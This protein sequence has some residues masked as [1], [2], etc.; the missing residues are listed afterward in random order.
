L[1]S[2]AHHD[3]FLSYA[4]DDDDERVRAIELALQRAGFSLWRDTAAISSRGL[5]FLEEIRRAI[6]TAGRVVVAIGPAAV[7]SEYVRME[8]QYALS[9]DRIVVPA[10]LVDD[11]DLVPPELKNLHTP[12]VEDTA[13]LAELIRVLGEEAPPLGTL[14][15]VP[16]PPPHYRPRSNALSELAACV[17]ADH[18]APVVLDDAGRRV[19]VHGMGGAGKT[20]LAG[21][22][23]RGAS[24]RRAFV[25]GVFWFNQRTGRPGQ[26]VADA[27]QTQF[28]DGT[29]AAKAC[30]IVLDNVDTVRFVEPLAAVL[31][32][33]SRIVVTTRD[34]RI[35][36]MLGA[37]RIDVDDLTTDEALEHLAD[38]TG[39]PLPELPDAA[40][41]L[42]RATGGNVL[43]LTLAGAFL[44]ASGGSYDDLL[45]ALASAD[46]ELLDRE[47]IG[48]EFDG[49]MRSIDASVTRL[50]ESG[51]ELLQDL[52]V[53]PAG[54]TLPISILKRMAVARGMAEHRVAAALDELGGL[55]LVRPEADGVSLH[56]LQRL[57]LAAT[58]PETALVHSRLLDAYGPP[59]TWNPLS[60]EPY[61]YE[62]LSHH[63]VHAGRRAVLVDL[64]TTS[65]A[66]MRTSIARLHDIEPV[67]AD[68]RRA[69]DGDRTLVEAVRLQTAYRAAGA[70]ARRYSPD[71]LRC[72]FR[73]GDVALATSCA[74]LGTIDH[75]LAVIAEGDGR[76]AEL[77]SETVELVQRVGNATA[78]AQ[79]QAALL[80]ISDAAAD[81]LLPEFLFSVEAMAE[82][83]WRPD[84]LAR[85]AISLLE[86]GR[87]SDARNLYNRIEDEDDD[88][89]AE[90]VA[91]EAVHLAR[92]E[93]LD[94][95]R[96]LLRKLP[97]PASPAVLLAILEAERR[98]GAPKAPE[99]L[100]RLL[101]LARKR[102]APPSTS[103]FA[104]VALF[105]WPDPRASKAFTS[106]LDKLAAADQDEA[107][108]G[109]R[110]IVAGLTRVD[111]ASSID[112]AVVML[113]H[114]QAWLEDE[115]WVPALYPQ[116]RQLAQAAAWV[117]SAL[118]R[119][120]RIDEAEQLVRYDR[121]DL[122]GVGIVDAIALEA[123]R[124]EHR[125]ARALFEEAVA[126]ND[127][128]QHV[129]SRPRVFGAV[130]MTLGE[131]QRPMLALAQ[132][133][134]LGDP[135]ALA[136]LAV[137]LAKAGRFDE[138]VVTASAIDH[139][140]LATA[141]RGSIVLEL[142]RAGRDEQA[143][144]LLT[145]L[146]EDSMPQ[147]LGAQIQLIHLG[148]A[149]AGAGWLA[150]AMTVGV[151][152]S[153]DELPRRRIRAHLEN[154][155][156]DAAL[157]EAGTL[158]ASERPG[159]LSSVAVRMAPNDRDRAREVFGAA[160][161]AAQGDD[162][163][164]RSIVFDLASSGFLDAAA[165][166]AG[167]IGAPAERSKA[168]SGAAKVALENEGAPSP[169]WLV[170][171]DE[172][173]AAAPLAERDEALRYLANA[174]M[175]FGFDSD[176][177]VDR[178]ADEATRAATHADIAAIEAYRGH[179]KAALDTY[180]HDD[181]ERWLE[182]TLESSFEV[183]R[184]A[185][186]IA[187]WVSP[188]W[189]T[190]ETTAWPTPP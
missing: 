131:K 158:S 84:V 46:P 83:S 91:E 99:E 48:Y 11:R 187:G 113:R 105:L 157:T 87:F 137:M 71:E 125:R 44:A 150:E 151:T 33:D 27:V 2:T 78:R 41:S 70:E 63:L 1:E 15:G 53:V 130:A 134:S 139:G 129:G 190:F 106:T 119:Q 162:A 62:F 152:E 20:V 32:S 89:H 7:R 88:R 57:Y 103:A 72:L 159:C 182:W 3:V 98:R 18:Q 14:H 120:D 127:R 107:F 96:E 93:H 141:A 55:M 50:T 108:T 36:D 16:S 47:L 166:T 177:V 189:K 172:A 115:E 178:I 81:E 77:F 117:A 160:V 73:L 38:W 132:E 156:L 30:L 97:A 175:T 61:L 155:E 8:W 123:A 109:L 102:R 67:R 9:A 75:R 124:F 10:L 13:G 179:L 28:A 133:Q 86:V 34:R 144:G 168:W 167:T 90:R 4:R 164:L 181:L 40:R 35:A 143:R 112:L 174:T 116:R 79:Y 186:P 163:A 60:T 146:V 100:R 140:R 12:V 58:C 145:E 37:R 22:F 114:W 183:F 173:L 176:A 138:A 128:A 23:A 24:A 82:V 85:G 54:A 142:I 148:D 39:T 171:A 122:H 149:L 147:D 69:L 118:V 74:R 185:V 135:R 6:R 49:V 65:P 111:S 161:V 136:D 19:V 180:P 165:E 31:G 29:V 45:S 43:A 126:T 104:L 68:V 184:D 92:V 153:G 25:D 21:A 42:I 17:L 56:D 95:A 59:E 170:R 80:S 101:E 188:S 66:W 110:E 121:S 26:A 51:R 64:L 76:D 169:E 94:E 5:S 154:G 52:V